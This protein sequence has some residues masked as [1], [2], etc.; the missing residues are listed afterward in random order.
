[1][2][3]PATVTGIAVSAPRSTLGIGALA[4][5]QLTLSQALTVSGGTP[6][7][8]LNDAG[9]ATYTSGSG[10]NTLSFTYQVQPGQD[11][12]DL[13]ITGMA[14]NGATIGNGVSGYGAPVT[15][16]VG[17]QAQGLVLADLNHDGVPDIAVA[18]TAGVAV[19]LADGHGGFGPATIIAG[20]AATGIAAADINGDGATDLLVDTTSGTE[21]LSGDGHGGFVLAP[22]GLGPGT[23]TG[24]IAVGPPLPNAARPDVVIGGLSFIGDNRF[25]PA[26]GATNF[27]IFIGPGLTASGV[28][29]ADLN[30]D[31][32]IDL[33]AA[34]NNPPGAPGIGGVVVALDPGP[35][36]PNT[37][38]TY[39]AGSNPVA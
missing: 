19:L 36:L 10:T 4:T 32:Q 37:V 2:T 3:A 27:P 7:L 8:L 33:I 14:L 23:S 12:T 15:Y 18:T 22:T 6:T 16:A 5:F 9:T 24:A 21:V 28:A 34:V 13:R 17:T 30:G 25:S 39:A 35:G 1:M 20:L 11:T 29:A 31:G 26:T 38:V